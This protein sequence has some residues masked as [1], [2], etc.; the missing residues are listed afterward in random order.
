MIDPDG[1]LDIHEA[2]RLLG[3]SATSLRRWTNSGLLPH[4]RIGGKR[5]LPTWEWLVRIVRYWDAVEQ[6]VR[7]RPAGPWF[8]VINEG[9]LREIP[10]DRYRFAEAR[11]S[12]ES[13]G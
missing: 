6:V 7:D 9:G 4:L 13:G 12:G 1:L 11:P 8:Y 5:D 10:L 2:A 3:V